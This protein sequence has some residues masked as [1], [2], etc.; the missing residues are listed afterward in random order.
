MLTKK[1][2]LML[3][4]LILGAWF[5]MGGKRSAG[6]KL[7]LLLFLVIV[8]FAFRFV[9]GATIDEIL[10]PFRGVSLF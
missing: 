7:G 4:I 1:M 5:L 8:Y 9:T 2:I 3:T 6:E 10:A